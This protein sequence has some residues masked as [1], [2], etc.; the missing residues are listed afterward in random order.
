MKIVDDKD[1]KLKRSK[2]KMQ[3]EKN[4]SKNLKRNEENGGLI[5]ILWLYDNVDSTISAQLTR[6]DFARKTWEYLK[7][8]HM[9]KDDAYNRNVHVKNSKLQQ[10]KKSIKAIMSFPSLNLNEKILMIS[11]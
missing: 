1:L 7:K 11:C 4:S 5:M 10:G 6:F 3:T 9:M 8:T 2:S